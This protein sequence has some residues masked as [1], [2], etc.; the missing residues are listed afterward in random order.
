VRYCRIFI[1]HLFTRGGKLSVL[2]GQYL[3]ATKELTPERAKS[4]GY[5]TPANVSSV[6]VSGAAPLSFVGH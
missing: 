2:E 1:R 3:A 4:M 6:V 5:V